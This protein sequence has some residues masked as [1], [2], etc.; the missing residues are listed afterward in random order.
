[1]ENV[2]NIPSLLTVQEETD[3]GES[4]KFSDCGVNRNSEMTVFS[5]VQQ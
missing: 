2:C 4:P 3:A 5:N 1:M